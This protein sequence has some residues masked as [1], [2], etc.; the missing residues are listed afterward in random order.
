MILIFLIEN[1][2]FTAK[3]EYNC[4]LRTNIINFVIVA[5]FQAGEQTIFSTF[6]NPFSQTST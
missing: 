5:L 3:M 1:I 4:L 2:A 6:L